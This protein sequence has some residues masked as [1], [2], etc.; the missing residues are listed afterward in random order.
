MRQAMQTNVASPMEW[1]SRMMQA[2]S[3]PHPTP[4]PA[5]AQPPDSPP[6]AQE[7]GESLDQ[8]RK[9]LAALQHR[10]EELGATRSRK[11]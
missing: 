10:V 8:L 11:K 3:G 1:A 9:Q 7:S 4:A 2:F 5:A 6:E